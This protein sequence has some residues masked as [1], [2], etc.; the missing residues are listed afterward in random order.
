[1]A[2]PA[3][4][5]FAMQVVTT[6]PSLTSAGS[7]IRGDSMQILLFQLGAKT[8]KIDSNLLAGHVISCHHF[9]LSFI[10]CCGFKVN[11]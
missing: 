5:A 4:A 3:A 8:S 2:C 10:G 11:H 9:S 6:G 1:M 7:I